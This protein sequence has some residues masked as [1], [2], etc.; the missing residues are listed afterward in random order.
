MAA[1][2]SYSHNSV[3]IYAQKY[4]DGK[5]CSNDGKFKL[6]T[7]WNGNKFNMA[8]AAILDFVLRHNLVTNEDF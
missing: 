6:A 7:Y 8:A 2:S 1:I 3:Q 5:L 4:F